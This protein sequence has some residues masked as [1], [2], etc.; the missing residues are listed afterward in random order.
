MGCDIHLVLE[1]RLINKDHKKY[2]F[3]FNKESGQY[4]VMEASGK[5]HEYAM[6]EQKKW[7]PCDICGSHTYGERIY[8]M[9]AN[10]AGV[11]G[12]WGRNDY[13]EPKGFPWDSSYAAQEGY[14]IWID[15]NWA[16]RYDKGEI[17]ERAITEERAKEWETKY[18]CKI[19][20]LQRWSG[21]VQ[22]RIVDPDYHSASWASRQ[23]LED[24]FNNLYRK[25]YNGKEVLIGT[26]SYYLGLIALMKAFEEDGEYEVRMVYW[27]DN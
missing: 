9:F 15:D 3:E 1:R 2:E 7:Q 17:D 16:E 13:P 20:D 18:K 11:R 4:E 19:I 6:E 21:D 22:K 24:A 26:Y 25:E 27:F 8:G 14:T 23:E 12:D 5:W 10:L